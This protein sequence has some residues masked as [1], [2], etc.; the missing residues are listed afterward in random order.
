[1]QAQGHKGGL[2]PTT[3]GSAQ[4]L[5][6]LKLHHPKTRVG[7]AK[8]PAH[9]VSQVHSTMPLH[10]R[11]LHGNRL[12]PVSQGLPAHLQPSRHVRKAPSQLPH[13]S[14]LSHILNCDSL[15]TSPYHVPQDSSRF[16]SHLRVPT[17]TI[18]GVILPFVSQ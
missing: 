8:L 17:R 4:Q 7:T 14:L 1:M 11:A 13:C 18:S 3:T 12:P 9:A 2:L 10:F 15:Q 16:T 5:S 6:L